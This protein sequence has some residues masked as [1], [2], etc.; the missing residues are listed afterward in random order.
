MVLDFNVQG[1][2]V[3][4]HSSM[5]SSDC[6]SKVKLEANLSLNGSRG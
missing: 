2:R 5:T 3:D 6:D 4:Y 1:L